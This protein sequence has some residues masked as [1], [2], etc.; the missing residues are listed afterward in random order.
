MTMTDQPA[1]IPTPPK[2]KR[3]HRPA[4]KR[5]APAKPQLPDEFAG[6]TD[7]QCP[8]ACRLGYCVFSNYGVCS[9]P[10]KGGQQGPDMQNPETFARFERAKK[11]LGHKKVDA[12]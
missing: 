6:L 2:K 7:K 10:R 4:R 3:K 9:H 5:A 8:T 1:P 12:A 11:V